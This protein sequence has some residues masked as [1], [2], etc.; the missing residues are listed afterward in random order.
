MK[1][2]G[3]QAQTILLCGALSACVT[4][5][6]TALNAE[7][8]GRE[9]RAAEALSGPLFDA[10][11][12]PD[13]RLPPGKV[14]LRMRD[15]RVVT[16]GQ[17]SL[18][19]PPKP[20]LGE[21]QELALRLRPTQVDRVAAW[22]QANQSPGPRGLRLE[23]TILEATVAWR[24]MQNQQRESVRVQAQVR[25]LD[26]DSGAVLTSTRT[27]THGH[28]DAYDASKA[29]V[30]TLL[31][32]A[33][34]AVVHQGVSRAPATPAAPDA[35]PRAQTVDAANMPAPSAESCVQR[36]GVGPSGG[37]GLW[38]DG[39][40]WRAAASARVYA[41]FPIAQGLM[42]GFDAEF[43]GNGLPSGQTILSASAGPR[44]S[45]L[46]LPSRTLRIEPSLSL[47]AGMGFTDDGAFGRSAAGGQGA[48]LGSSATLFQPTYQITGSSPSPERAASDLAMTLA[49]RLG[50]GFGWQPSGPDAMAGV[51]IEPYVQ[52]S[53]LPD[54]GLGPR[55]SAGLSLYLSVERWQDPKPASLVAPAQEP[56]LAPGS[57]AR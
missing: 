51:T 50:L 23:V 40:L 47:L 5:I 11:A 43:G 3:C 49:G 14:A 37:F 44:A 21:H 39:A 18:R 57:S 22:V 53:G 38:T 45:Y 7:A 4:P 27:Q 15:A 16:Q 20:N 1:A 42:L 10:S 8:G 54:R 12:Q 41:V 30:L 35:Y 52:I 32:D 6:R 48:A 25:L 13:Y 28:R 31:G 29:G 19:I 34:V 24:A 36:G 17:Y 9:D 55:I 26:A 56:A 2:R 46:W 33:L